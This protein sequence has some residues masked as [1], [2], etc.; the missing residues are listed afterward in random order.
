MLIGPS[1]GDITAIKECDLRV[2]F[3]EVSLLFWCGRKTVIREV[4]VKKISLK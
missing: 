3:W 2:C 4:G 1:L